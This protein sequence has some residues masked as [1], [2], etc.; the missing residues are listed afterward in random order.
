MIVIK[1]DVMFLVFL[2][3]WCWISFILELAFCESV[4]LNPSLIPC[5]IIL[6]STLI[7]IWIWNSEGQ[8]KFFPSNQN[9]FSP[10]Q[11]GKQEK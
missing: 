2:R 5:E 11:D 7:S 9:T 10:E 1:K 4:V 6:L 8:L 3:F